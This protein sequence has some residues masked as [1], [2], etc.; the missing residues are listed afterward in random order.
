[1]G[2]M[3]DNIQEI[4]LYGKSS[5]RLKLCHHFL[6]DLPLIKS[7]CDRNIVLMGFNPGETLK[8]WE[9]TKFERTEETSRYDFLNVQGLRKNNLWTRRVHEIL[10]GHN[11][12]Q[13]ELF[14]WSSPNVKTLEQRIPDLYTSTELKFCTRKNIELFQFYQ[15]KCIIFTGLSY[16]KRVSE[17]FDLEKQG[18][19]FDGTQRVFVEYLDKFQRTWL[20]TKHFTGSFG[21][22]TLHGNVIRERILE[23]F[24]S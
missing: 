4:D 11:V 7:S 20:I 8:D 24:E 5:E 16:E 12:I 15:P 19:Y 1:M 21:F 23:L 3:Q 22:K 2:K 13:T 14:F 10:F 9:S 17:I 6:Y 18:E